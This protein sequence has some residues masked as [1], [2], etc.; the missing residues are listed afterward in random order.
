MNSNLYRNSRYFHFAQTGINSN[1]YRSRAVVSLY[2]TGIYFYWNR[3]GTFALHKHGLTSTEIEQVLSLCTNKVLTQTSV[4]KC[5][6]TCTQSSYEL[7]RLTLLG[8]LPASFAT[9]Q[10]EEEVRWGQRTDRGS[11][12]D[13]RAL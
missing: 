7:W 1:L 9:T 6:S 13:F 11:S 3:A 2:T 5:T 8:I 4:P 12:P 10:T